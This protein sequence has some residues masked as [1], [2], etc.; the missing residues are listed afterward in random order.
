MKKKSEKITA[1]QFL[2]GFIT[3]RIYYWSIIASSLLLAVIYLLGFRS[4]DYVVFPNV[5]NF[6]ISFYNDSV[7]GGNSVILNSQVTD[8]AITVNF[9]LKDGFVRP[10]I[11]ITLIPVGNGTCDL[12]QFNQ[13]EIEAQGE[14]MDNMIAYLITQ[15][16]NEKIEGRFPN[17]YLG[18]NINVSQSK[19]L[20]TI[21]FNQFKTPDWWYDLNNFSPT[22]EILP[23]WQH[24]IQLNFTTGLTPAVDTPRA[25]RISSIRFSR[26]NT[27]V[28][29]LMCSIELML[30]ISLLLINWMRL[31]RINRRNSLTITY[32][33]VEVEAKKV[34]H[35]NFLDYIHANFNDSELSLEVVSNACDVSQRFIA[36]TISEKYHCNFKTYINQIRINEAKR[37][38]LETD[39]NI[40]EIAYKVGFNSPN[41]FNRVFKALTGNNPSGFMNQAD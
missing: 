14:N 31:R 19:Q 9:V 12:S 39:L 22:K 2:V 33:P 7:D 1:Q 13:F 17:F 23:D 11:G 37:L 18:S 10:Y 36:G 27:W 38:M 40:S 32:K 24:V 6:Q 16:I 4:D 29:L 21:P 35:N 20:S 34:P 26:H 8:S 28:L 5:R 30:I 15:T 25:L 3:N 41:H